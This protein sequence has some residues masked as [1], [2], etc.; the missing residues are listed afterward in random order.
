MIAVLAPVPPP[1]AN[2][3]LDELTAKVAGAGRPIRSVE[4]LHNTSREMQR[5]AEAVPDG[6]RDAWVSFS[7]KFNPLDVET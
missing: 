1:Q 7:K 2:A 5:Q 4:E 3:F 6:T